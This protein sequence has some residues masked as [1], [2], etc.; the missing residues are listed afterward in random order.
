MVEPSPKLSTLNRANKP[1]VPVFLP[2]GDA[3]EVVLV[4]EG[5]PE[6]V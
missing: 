2:G 5:L 6:G 3:Q 4:A 1:G